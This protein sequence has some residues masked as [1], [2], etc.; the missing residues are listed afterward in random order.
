MA[1]TQFGLALGIIL[2]LATQASIAAIVPPLPQP[3]W[4]ELTT[5]QQRILAPL[6]GEWDTMEG[7][8]RK[9]WLGIAQRYQTLSPDEQS[10]MQRRMTSWAK[11]TPEE[12]KR[13]RDQYLSLK[14][15]SPEKKEEV[16][17]KWE[18]YKELPEAEKA[19]LKAEAAR[20]STPRPPPSKPPL[21]KVPDTKTP[22]SNKAGPSSSTTAASGLATPAIVR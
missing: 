17:Q 20:K 15:A 7:F 10:R 22:T 1:R 3:S 6:S 4:K 16:K 2:W 9:K 8:R 18:A 11:L 21:N 14:K 19:R 13:A 5:D 12:R